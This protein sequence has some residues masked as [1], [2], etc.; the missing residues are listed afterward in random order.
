MDDV[1]I[2]S[3]LFSRIFRRKHL[4][5]GGFRTPSLSC[6]LRVGDSGAA[7][8]LCVG[9]CSLRQ[10]TVVGVSLKRFMLRPGLLQTVVLRPG[11]GT[12]LLVKRTGLKSEGFPISGGL[13]QRS[14]KSP[15]EKPFFGCAQIALQIFSKR[16]EFLRRFL[17]TFSTS[18]AKVTRS[19]KSVNTKLV[20]IGEGRRTA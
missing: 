6:G 17:D 12:A 4:G 10:S 11:L 13:R 15:A 18:R 20:S 8:M 1:A 7:C 9:P 19:L 14:G 16:S 5:V 3:F 2:A